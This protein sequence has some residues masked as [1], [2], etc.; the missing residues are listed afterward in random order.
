M[1]LDID[2]YQDEF[3]TGFRPFG[4]STLVV[5]LLLVL[6]GGMAWRAVLGFELRSVKGDI[7][8]VADRIDQLNGEIEAL[9]ARLGSE[10]AKQRIQQRI[11]GLREAI[12]KRERLL[13]DMAI[14]KGAAGRLPSAYLEGVARQAGDGLWLS[15]LAVDHRAD[16]VEIRGHATDPSR[17]PAF[18]GRLGD[19]IAF[20]GLRFRRLVISRNPE[21]PEWV[22]F[23]VMTSEE[24]GDGD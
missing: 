17:V 24:V 22:D 10:E 8:R 11:T 14:D 3:R 2:L 20:R 18:V 16:Q 19:E 9:S 12:G 6:L 5:L 4:L 13:A 15:H 23:R 7:E 21:R 1:K